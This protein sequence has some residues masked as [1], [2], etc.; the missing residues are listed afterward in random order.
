MKKSIFIIATALAAAFSA[1]TPKPITEDSIFLTEAQVNEIVAQDGGTL[2]TLNEFMDRYMTETGNFKDDSTNYRTRTTNGDGVYLFSIDT[3]PSVGNGIYI[4]GRV[5]TDD[6]G[7]NFYKTLCIQQI[8]NGEQ[9]A[10]RISVDASSV[11]GMYPM[12][13]ELLIRVN[14]LAIGRYADQPQLCVPSY[15]NNYTASNAAQKVGWAPGRIPWARFQSAV[16]RIGKPDEK[17]LQVDTVTISEFQSVTAEADMRKWDAKLV[18][19]KDIWYTGEYEYNGSFTPCTM[20]D[21]QDDTNAN[22]FA[23]TTN[24]VGFPQSRVITDGIAK[25]LVSS[26]EYAKFAHFYLPGADENG[27][28]ECSSWVGNVTGILGQYRD[29]AKYAHDKYDW[30]ITIRGLWDLDLYNVAGQ[31]WYPDHCEEY[32]NR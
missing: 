6:Y 24:N 19:V 22:V 29:N 10:L 5:T 27:I 13:Q 12:G 16:K 30:S 31:S 23:P 18:C 15:N 25:T 26:S 1:C 7:G 14:G 2:Y 9:Q 32:S 11:N 21:P 28:L 4:R 3:L 20:G 8:V 17:K